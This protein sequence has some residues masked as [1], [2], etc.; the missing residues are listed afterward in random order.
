MSHRE[1]ETILRRIHPAASVAEVVVRTGGRSSPVVEVRC[2]P[3]V[4]PVVIKFYDGDS[5]WKRDKE[6]H[7][8]RLLRERGVRCVPV[9]LGSGGEGAEGALGRGHLVMSRLDGQPLSEVVG[10]L[11]ASAVAGIYEEMGALLARM[12]RIPQEAY[13]YLTTG[14]LDPCATN[15]QY[16]QRQ[17]EMKMREFADLGGDPN[18]R[19][20]MEARVRDGAGLFDN[21]TRPVLCH[22]DF[23]EGNV[24][25]HEV[26]GRR[27]IAGFID[28]ENAIAADPLMDLAKTDYYS[29]RGNRN[30]QDA[31]HR[32]YGP[33]PA[34]ATERISLYR[35]YQALELWDWFALTG[36]TAALPGIAEDL[37]KMAIDL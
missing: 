12:H 22:N 19:K 29:I 13:G 27:R 20:A 25:L 3:P 36:E 14:I 15:A 5:R 24:L 33:L 35:L 32:G 28:V 31:L 23:H 1:A 9:V 8:Y 21:C 6:V 17:F 26:A 37:A 4:E 7:V 34:D 16:M 2:A 18:L 30:K 10:E 11:G